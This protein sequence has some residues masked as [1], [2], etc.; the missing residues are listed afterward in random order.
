MV[1]TDY[2]IGILV[3]VLVTWPLTSIGTVAMMALFMGG[4][5]KYDR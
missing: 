2:E 5:D 3:G 1:M 4:R